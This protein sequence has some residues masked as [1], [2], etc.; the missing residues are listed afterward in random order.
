MELPG[1]STDPLPAPPLGAVVLGGMPPGSDPPGSWP[2]P[3]GPPLE[4][5]EPGSGPFG[6]GVGGEGGALGVGWGL[7][8]TGV[9]GPLSGC[10]EYASCT[11]NPKRSICPVGEPP[12]Y[13]WGL[14]A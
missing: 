7:G 1:L 11:A 12:T 6:V 14:G 3:C 5:G 8:S 13:A 2:G 4:L 10:G 9:D